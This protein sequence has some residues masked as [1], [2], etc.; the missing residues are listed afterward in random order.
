M[1]QQGSEHAVYGYARVLVDM[2]MGGA[3][4]VPAG[5]RVLSEVFSDESVC[6]FFANPGVSLEAKTA[7]LEHAKSAC[8]L[9]EVLIRFVCVVVSDGLFPVIGDIFDKFFVMLRK[10]RGMYNLEVVTAVPLTQREEKK[11]LDTLKAQY[12]VPER[13]T[14]RVDP[15]ILG[16][17]IAR[18]DSFVVDA[19]YSGCLRELHRISREAIL[20]I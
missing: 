16:G 7:V 8:G 13:V 14:K 15:E 3:D 9:D 10:K 20:N 1:G 18:G 17:F 5:V 2:V 19:S 4:E 12:G 11:I 6:A